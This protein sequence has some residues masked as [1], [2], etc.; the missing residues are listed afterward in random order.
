MGHPM[1]PLNV[2]GGVSLIL[3]ALALLLHDES[4]RA[5]PSPT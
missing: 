1:P 3:F 2:L 5:R 4:V